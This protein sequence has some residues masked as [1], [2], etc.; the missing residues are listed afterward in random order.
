MNNLQNSNKLMTYLNDNFKKIDNISINKNGYIEIDGVYRTNKKEYKFIIVNNHLLRITN[1][2]KRYTHQI[3][4]ESGV[5]CKNIDYI[6]LEFINN[7]KY[8]FIKHY[9]GK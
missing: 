6:D 4:G 2:Y 9:G 7:Y 8:D 1:K 5:N 3:N